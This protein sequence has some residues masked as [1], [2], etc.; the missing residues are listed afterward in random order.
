MSEQN[1]AKSMYRQI[2]IFLSEGGLNGGRSTYMGAILTRE[3][4]YSLRCSFGWIGSTPPCPLQIQR[5]LARQHGVFLD[6]SGYWN[7]QAQGGPQNSGAT[8]D[9]GCRES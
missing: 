6:I 2:R 7:I 9:T 3:A 1:F 5:R 4:G 8:S